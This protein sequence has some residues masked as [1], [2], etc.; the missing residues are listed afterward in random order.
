MK[1]IGIILAIIGAVLIVAFFALRTF[2]KSA[3]PEAVA[4]FDQNGFTLKVDYCRPARKG[5]P[6]FGG[7]VPYGEVWRTGANE[8][9]VIH[10]GQDVI[11]AGQ[12]L[13]AGDY[14]LWTIPSPQGWT[15]IINGETGQWGTNYDQKQDVMRVQ[16]N[17][18][19][20][21]PPMEQFL[22]SFVPA[23]NGAD[24]LLTW[25]QTEAIVPIRQ[26]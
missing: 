14:S 10:L 5:R 1:R 3:S 7:L 11:L 23:S 17:T 25:D 24:M 15:V 16:V 19:P 12:S 6:I 22:I 26:P 21:T 20:H 8:A 2:T 9:T 4:Q 18:R 13:K